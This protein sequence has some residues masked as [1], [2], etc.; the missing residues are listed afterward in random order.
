MPALAT[1]AA[2]F[3]TPNSD[4]RLKGYLPLPSWPTAVDST[5][6]WDGAKFRNDEQYTYVLDTDEIVEIEA[7]MAHF[8]GR[9][10]PI[11]YNQ[12]QMGS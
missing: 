7:A 2:E 5:L 10:K 4:Q 8:K 6:A 11:P 12:Y 3:E 9:G 1:V